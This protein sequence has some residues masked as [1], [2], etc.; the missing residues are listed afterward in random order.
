M[1]TLMSHEWCER[2]LGESASYPGHPLVVA[3]MIMDRYHSFEHASDRAPGAHCENARADPFIVG[4]GC[5]V[6]SALDVLRSAV[7]GDV[8]AA[9][10]HA[11]RYWRAWE[12]QLPENPTRGLVGRGQA[13]RV[14]PLFMERLKEWQVGV[15]M[16]SAYRLAAPAEAERA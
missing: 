16:D 15:V 5:A 11:E 13:D 2:H 14:R 3:T 7:A 9:M 1:P 6:L 10:Q 8:G 12:A 4:A